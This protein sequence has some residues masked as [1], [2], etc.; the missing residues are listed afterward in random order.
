MRPS[1][2]AELAYLQDECP[3]ARLATVGRGGASLD[4]PS[5]QPLG[6]PDEV[7]EDTSPVGPRGH[8]EVIPLRQERPHLATSAD[9]N[10][11]FGGRW[12]HSAAPR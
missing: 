10:P 5:Q 8:H 3:L 2:K 7:I 9:S 1:G 4:N 12:R 6:R 11:A